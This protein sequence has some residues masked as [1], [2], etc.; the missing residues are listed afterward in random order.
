MTHI[1]GLHKNVT[2]AVQVSRL[3]KVVALENSALL[4]S[5][6][7]ASK[8]VSTGVILDPLCS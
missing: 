6:S 3:H 5:K 2:G 7:V 1:L 8:G 4:W